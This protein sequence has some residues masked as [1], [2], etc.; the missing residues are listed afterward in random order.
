MV[1]PN[2]FKD[3]ITI[4]DFQKVDLRVGEVISAEKMEKSDKLLILKVNVS[5]EI[6]QIVSGIADFYSP[7]EMVGKKVVVVANLKPIKLRGYDSQGMILA[8]S[9][10]KKSLEVLEVEKENS[11]AKVG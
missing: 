11:N 1:K 6:R 3:E 5:G 9:S 4:D 7:E 2:D 8:A 10:S